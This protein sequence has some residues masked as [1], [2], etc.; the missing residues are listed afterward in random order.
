LTHTASL[1]QN[2]L[3]QN[4]ITDFRTGAES[5]ETVL[6]SEA[7]KKKLCAKDGEYIKNLVYNEAIFLMYCL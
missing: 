5:N 6:L 7:W 3:C 4:T 2:W 1:D